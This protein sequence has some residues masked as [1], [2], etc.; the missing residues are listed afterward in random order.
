MSAALEVEG[1]SAGYG[2]VPVL[3]EVSMELAEGTIT[4]VL[5]ANGAGKTTLLRTL[6]GLLPATAG[7]VALDGERPARG[8]G[9]GDGAPRHRARAR[10]PRGGRRADRRGEPAPRRAV[11]LRPRRRPGDR[12][13]CARCMSCSSRSRGGGRF[14]GH[15]LSGGE[16]QMLALGRALVGAAAAAAARRAVAR[17]GPAGD[18]PDH[19]AAA[20]P[21]R[22]HRADRAAGRAERAQRAVDRRPGR[23]ARAGPGRRPGPAAELAADE[24]SATRTW[25]SDEQVHSFPDLQRARR[26]AVY[27]AFALALVLIWRATRVLN[28]AQGAL[29]VAT[30]Y[31]AVLGH[32]RLGLVLARLRRRAGRRAALGAIDPAARSLPRRRADAGPQ[33]HRG[34]GRLC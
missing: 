19:G 13:A 32:R 34:G 24:T 28:F 17:A 2:R 9:G 18:R 29:A 14:P 12:A 21:A 15:Q 8:A 6:S 33:H 11:A 30:A 10:G 25:G 23:R 16:R 7:R 1:L 20:R 5:G 4:A 3:H 26:G 31:V 22:P 27:A